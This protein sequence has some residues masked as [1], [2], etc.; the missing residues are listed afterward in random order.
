MRCVSIRNGFLNTVRQGWSLWPLIT[1]LY[2][3][4]YKVLGKFYTNFR[5]NCSEKQGKLSRGN[6]IRSFNGPGCY[7]SAYSELL[8]SLHSTSYHNKTPLQE[9]I[10][11][12]MKCDTVHVTKDSLLFFFEGIGFLQISLCSVRGLWKRRSTIARTHT[13]T[14]AYAYDILHSF[15]NTIHFA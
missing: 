5:D 15:K 9:C 10:I 11:M 2:R 14:R 13:R 3:G 6:N 8:F 12:H 4:P 7:P 1:S